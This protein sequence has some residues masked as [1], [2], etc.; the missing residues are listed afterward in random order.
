MLMISWIEGTA[1]LKGSH[2]SSDKGPVIQQ[3]QMEP[4]STDN[5]ELWGNS[6][7]AHDNPQSDSRNL[8]GF[9]LLTKQADWSVHQIIAMMTCRITTAQLS[10]SS[11]HMPVFYRKWGH[12][13]YTTWARRSNY[14]QHLSTMQQAYHKN[15]GLICPKGNISIKHDWL[16]Q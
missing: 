10:M 6:L 2:R 5:R 14:P 7:G 13:K 8:I 9:K 16:V 3:S 12:I 1:T 11:L 4:L 15:T